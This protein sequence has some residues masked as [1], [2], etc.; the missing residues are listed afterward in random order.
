MNAADWGSKA[1]SA[2]QQTEDRDSDPH[3]N[4]TAMDLADSLN[5]EWCHMLVARGHPFGIN[6]FIDTFDLFST[7]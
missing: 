1:T 6:L 5:Q 7:Q 3:S 2:G 4:V